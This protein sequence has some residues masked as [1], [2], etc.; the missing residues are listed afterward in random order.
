MNNYISIITL[1]AS[2]FVFNQTYAQKDCK[3]LYDAINTNYE[4][5]CKKGLAHGKGIA[6]GEDTYEGNFKKGLPHGKGTY[7]YAEGDNYTGAWKGG[8]RNG[9]GTYNDTQGGKYVGTWKQGLKH[10]E[11]TYYLK[12]DNRDT[13]LAGIWKDDEYVGP[14]QKKPYII[15]SRRSVDRVT[16]FRSGD[17]NRLT[18]KIMQSGVVNSTVVDYRFIWSSGNELMLGSHARG[19]EN[20]EFPFEGRITYTT[21]NKLRTST[22]VV[23]VEFIVNE[24]GEWELILHN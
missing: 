1:I 15:T 14:K 23:T 13:T 9:Y 19:W 24:P 22:Y 2:L 4:G 20:M 11:G 8:E 7:T 17:G 10:G 18:I 3:V 12:M 5:G 16:M 6:K 21:S